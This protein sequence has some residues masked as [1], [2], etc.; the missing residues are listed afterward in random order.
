MVLLP[1]HNARYLRKMRLD[2]CPQD[3]LTWYIVACHF[4]EWEDI[5]SQQHSDHTKVSGADDN[6]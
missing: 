5:L 2:G 6:N 1:L 4:V 3:A